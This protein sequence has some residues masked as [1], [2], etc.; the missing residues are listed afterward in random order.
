MRLLVDVF[1]LRNHIIREYAGYTTSFLNILDPDIRSHVHQELHRGKLWPDA[2][3]QLSPAYAQASTVA[4][5]VTSGVLHQRCDDIFKAPDRDGVLRPLRLYYHQRQ[6]ID[7]AAQR[8]HFVV[9]TGTGSGKSMTYI[10]P[11]IDHV[12]KHNPDSGKVRA[13]IVYP[14]NALI[15]SQE[16]ALTR[17]MDNL[18]PDARKVTFRRYTGQESESEKREIQENPP[19]ILLTNYV[20]LEYLLIRPYERVFLQQATRELRWVVLDELH[21][22]RGRQGSDVAMLLRRVKQRSANP[23]LQF[24]G[25]SATLATDGSR[26][27]RLARIAEVGRTLFGVPVT[28]ANVVDETLRRQATVPAPRDRAALRSAVQAEP[29]AHT[30][31]AVRAHPLVSWVEEAFGVEAEAGRLVRRKPVTFVEGLR[32]LELLTGLD[33]PLCDAQ[34][35]A[36]L[37]AGNA[38]RTFTGDPV[39]AF[40]LHQFLS[41]GSSVFGTLQPAGSRY[42]TTEGQ[43]VAPTSAGE[44]GERLLFPLAFCRDCGQEYYLVSRVE[45]SS[46]TVRFLPRSP[47][48]NAFEDETLGSFGFFAPERDSLWAEDEDL[49]ELW[50]EQRAGGP[51]VKSTYASFVPT[52][53]RLSSNGSAAPRPE[54]DAFEGWYM[55]RPLMLCLRCRASYDLRQRSDFSKLATLSQTGRS[56]ATTILTTSTVAAMRAAQDTDPEAR[57][58]LSFTDN[59]QDASLQAGHLNDFVQVVLL[60]GALVR[61]LPTGG[62]LAFEQ[63]GTS[64]FQ[65]LNLKPAEFM[66]E[67][68]DSGPGYESARRTMVDLLA[69]RAFEDLRRAWRVAQPNLEQVGLLRVTYQ[70]LDDV[71]ADEAR[72]RNVPTLAE[73]S[74][75]RRATVLRALLDH[76]RYELVIDAE[77]LRS[78]AIRQLAQRANQWLRNPW[79]IDEFERLRRGGLALLPGVDVGRYSDDAP[80]TIR[81]GYR[82][83]VGRYLRSRRTW[84]LPANLAADRAEALVAAIVAGLRGDLLT[85]IRRDG[86]DYGVQLLSGAL[87]WEDGDGRG[88]GPDP[89]RA[90]SLHLR[91]EQFL[92]PDPNRYFEQLYRDRAPLLTGISGAEHTGQVSAENRI[93]RER[94]FRAGQLATLFCSPTM[95][96]GIDIADLSAVHLRNVPPTP[97]NYAQRSG[98]AGRGGRPAL[99]LAFASQGNAHDQHF[100]REKERMIAGSVAPPRMDL[101]NRDLVEAHLHA[102]WLAN[103]SMPLGQSIA[104]LLDTDQAG[105]PLIAESAAKLQLS[106]TRQREVVAT[107]GEVAASIGTVSQA[108]WFTEAWIEETVRQAPTRFDR[109]FDRWRELYRAAVQQRDLARRTIDRPRMDRKERDAAEQLEREAKR[110]IELLL[111]Q[112][113]AREESDFYPYRYLASE[114]LLPGYNFPR[115]P[116]RVLVPGRDASHSI[117]RPRFLGL[118][119]F[120]PLNLIYHEGRKHRVTTCILP[121]GGIDARLISAKC[122]LACG[123]IHPGEV[124]QAVDLC[125]HCGTRLDGATMDYPQALLNQPT[126][127]ASR[128]ARISSDEEERSREGYAID[129]HFRFAPGVSTVRADLVRGEDVLLEVLYAPQSELWRI[130]TGW[131]RARRRNGFAIDAETGR[132]GKRDDGESEDDGPDPG[133][134]RTDRT[135]VK[136]YVTDNRNVLLLRPRIGLIHSEQTHTSLAY[137]LQRGLQFVFQVEEQEVAV[138][139]IGQGDEQRLLLWE[140]AEGGTG[141]WERLLADREALAGVAREALRVCHFDATSGEPD[142]AWTGRCARACYDCLLSY[143]NQR[144]HRQLDRYAIRDYLLAVSTADLVRRTAERTYDEQYRWLLDRVDPQSS[145]ERQ[146][147]DLLH[148][149]KLRLPDLAQHRPSADVAVQ[150]DFFYE[151]DGLPGVCIFVDGPAHAQPDQAARDRSLRD[152]LEDRGYRV[153][154][155]RFDDPI[156]EQLMRHPET[157]GAS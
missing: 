88:V 42:L 95:E 54:A 138:E 124:A 136:P 125:E 87:R 63:V 64:A 4:D 26:E 25:T 21:V 107:F 46:G 128:W 71:A 92:T 111:N 37:A 114:S 50:F 65:A 85:V 129:T 18:P 23:E 134:E 35:K 113:E 147:I 99:V 20:M 144:D 127:R 140:A 48:L 73:A 96:L 49:P 94:A 98:R 62:S 103:V 154:A 44:T 157:F 137:A 66:R 84:D 106:E 141:V 119:E 118:S 3:I 131:R 38:V 80:T 27:E 155:I 115:L 43:Y 100:F 39:F 148:E 90:R 61:A 76:L 105:Y 104:D 13:I 7:L 126:V 60:R 117:D 133:A 149:L 53:C 9:T 11:I 123:Y 40:R 12:L 68:R 28:P 1:Q 112:S 36:T 153:H 19:H 56:T 121:A 16:K 120:G 70:G 31:E 145:L 2:L 59:R 77:C 156:Y 143:S 130:N 6:A 102:V 108:D 91:P 151:R 67:P 5:L 93:A 135:G 52:R 8:Q 55:P 47:L 30:L 75:E 72:W 24:V 45:E 152:A 78:D 29:P 57:K 58:V 122:C 33:A 82:S 17:F 97:A 79:S 51:R 109:A 101:A 89:V 74:P 41:S 83:A 132:W 32:Q 22:Y 116:L 150:V 110:E 14:M 10:V 69:Y 139:L 146:F 15:N 34:L 81:L 142:P 86:Q